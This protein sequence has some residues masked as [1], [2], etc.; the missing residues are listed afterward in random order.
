MA[1]EQATEQM[2]GPLSEELAAEVA[3]LESHLRDLSAR[4]SMA[5][6]AHETAR[7]A[8]IHG[9]GSTQDVIE[10]QAA[11]N[12]LSGVREEVEQLLSDARARLNAQRA[13]D[14]REAQFEQLREL[15]SECRQNLD[16]YEAGMNSLVQEISHLLMPVLDRYEHAVALRHRFIAVA[17]EI[18]PGFSWAPDYCER[19]LNHPQYG[20]KAREATDLL[21]ELQATMGNEF[22][23]LKRPL[24][25]SGPSVMDELPKKFLQ[26][27][28][29]KPAYSFSTALNHHLQNAAEGAL[30][31]RVEAEKAP[32][33][34]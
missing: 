6:T 11:R 25:G 27:S 4:S 20:P 13:A 12:A 7:A 31:N 30:A 3:R 10:A 17:F 22:E 18:A 32:R 14:W 9:S 28:I 34:R 15:A 23:A 2:N 19:Y 21:R 5:E 8:L 16:D 33:R 1:T 26:L 24:I 29:G